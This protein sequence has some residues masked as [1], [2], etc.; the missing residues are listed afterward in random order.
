LPDF[1]A[2]TYADAAR[3]GNRSIQE[4]AEELQALRRSTIA[5]FRS[6][7]EEMTDRRGESTG[8]FRFAVRAFP[9]IIAGHEIHHQRLIEQRYLASTRSGCR[10]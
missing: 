1:D 9:W 2:D 3:A 4:L 10:L 6:F 8:G 7:D 5:L